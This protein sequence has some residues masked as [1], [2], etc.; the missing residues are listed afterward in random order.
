[1]FKRIV[2][3]TDL[4]ETSD[5]ALVTAVALA[6][7]DGAALRIVHVIRDPATEPW[8]IEAY[9]FD[10]SML[11]AQARER[12]RDDV[13]ARVNRILDTA[14]DRRIEIRVGVAAAEI[15]RYATEVSADLI[16]MGSHG[17]GLIGRALL[18][19]VAQRVLHDAPC[20]VL[21]VRSA[22]SGEGISHVA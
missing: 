21:V 2:A 15:V 5:D 1:M 22:A 11:L 9:G 4:S 8:A 20:P 6:R 16:V 10:F 13:A 14:P 12:A 7:E 3:A 19:S 18:G 17:R